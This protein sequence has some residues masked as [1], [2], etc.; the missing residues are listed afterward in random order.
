MLH[1]IQPQAQAR[2]CGN[3]VLQQQ[4]GEYGKKLRKSE[5]PAFERQQT[6]IAVVVHIVWHYPDEHLCD[7]TVFAQ[8][9]ALNRDFSSQNLDGTL[10][11]NEFESIKS[12]DT[13][14]RFCLASF[15]P[16]GLQ[17]TGIVRTYSPLAE[18]GVS[19]SLFYSDRGGSDAWDA[20]RYLNVWVANT[21]KFIAGFGTYPGLVPPEKSGVVV[22]PKYFGTQAEGRFNLGRTV[23]HEVGHYLGLLH[24]WAGGNCDIGDSIADTPPQS[25]AYE[26]CPDY[27]Q[28][29]CGHSNAFMNYM[30]YVD[31]GCMVMFTEGQKGIMLAILETLR[32]SLGATQTT[33][34][35]NLT[36]NFDFKIYP[37][38]T[39]GEIYLSMQ[40]PLI[41]EAY[42]IQLLNSLGQILSTPHCIRSTSAIQVNVSSLAPG[43]YFVRIG[44][45]VKAF[46]K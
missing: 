16:A 28:Y 24:P 23:V 11:P 7:E 10:V 40:N 12:G 17:T 22:H 44:K 39:S 35:A 9:E 4:F 13:G 5:P 42:S 21:G 2:L 34:S 25:L 27:P 30:D 37:N 1:A 43:I 19:D 46:A 33:C 31:D 20:E 14:I 6:T 41:A 45:V 18:A 3:E 8:I 36:N 38:P 32:P 15:D 26:G 29:S